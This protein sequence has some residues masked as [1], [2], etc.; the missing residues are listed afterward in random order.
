MPVTTIEDKKRGGHE[1]EL[2]LGDVY[3]RVTR[4]ERKGKFIKYIIISK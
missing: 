2:E 3:G 1:L 4:E